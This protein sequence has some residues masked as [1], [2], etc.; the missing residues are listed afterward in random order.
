VTP[1]PYQLEGR[2]FLAGKR[3]ALL[4]DEMRV[5]KTPQAILACQAIGAQSV[6]VICPAIAVPHWQREFATWW[7]DNCAR[8]EVFSYD[9][10]RKL[11]PDCGSVDVLIA[12]EAHYAK[13]PGAKRTGL[14][15]GKNGLGWKAQ[16]LW[17]LSGTPAP[18]HAGELWPMLRAFG[19]VGMHYDD[20]CDRFCRFSSDGRVTGTR[21][22][23]IPELRQLLAPIMLRR[24]RAQVAPDMEPIAFNI[25][26]VVPKT[27]PLDESG[28]P[29]AIDPGYLERNAKHLAEWRIAVAMA[30]VPP[31]VE[32]IT[33]DLD[34]A[35]IRQT[36]VFGVHIEPLTFLCNALNDAGYN[37]RLLTGATSATDREKII[38]AFHAGEVDV[39]CANIIAAGTAIDLSAAH[40]GYFLE[41][42]WTPG[43]NL[44]AANRLVALDKARPVTYD[45]VSWQRSFDDRIQSVLARRV[46]ELAQLY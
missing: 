6:R 31:L 4:A 12:D 23:R 17:A 36:V 18:R 46:R 8:L 3:R 10:A 44:Q 22:D 32:Q 20:F 27:K 30:K 33:G 34:A 13:N 43:N 45:I 35:L 38:A 7:P 24:T 1:R 39:I 29:E 19:I 37:A 15:Y 41:Q 16:R 42:D 28:M 26:P 11:A 21:E 2:D 14:I 40:H 25:L 5:G 9:R